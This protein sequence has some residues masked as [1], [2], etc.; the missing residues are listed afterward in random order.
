MFLVHIFEMFFLKN[1]F[2][3]SRLVALSVSHGNLVCVSFEHR[4]PFWERELWHLFG[5]ERFAFID[6]LG[7]TEMTWQYFKRQPANMGQ[8]HLIVSSLTRQS[9]LFCIILVRKAMNCMTPSHF[10]VLL[11]MRL[12]VMCWMR[13]LERKM[14]RERKGGERSNVTYI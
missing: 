3:L 9:P 4:I 12:K 11:E 2:F 5:R 7:G 8:R 13:S 6:I 10:F 14:R 1:F